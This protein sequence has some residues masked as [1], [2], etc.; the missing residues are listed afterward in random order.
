ML[1]KPKLDLNITKTSSGLYRFGYTNI[2]AALP[3]G[4]CSD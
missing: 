3:G 2:M 1:E 4:G